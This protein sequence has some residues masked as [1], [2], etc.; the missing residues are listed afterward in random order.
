M[1]LSVCAPRTRAIADLAWAFANLE[2][3]PDNGLIER[4]VEVSGDRVSEFTNSVRPD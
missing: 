3:L 4:M 1:C 2:Y